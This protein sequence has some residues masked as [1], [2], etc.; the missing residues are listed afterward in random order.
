MEHASRLRYAHFAQ[1][2]L[3]IHMRCTLPVGSFVA[4]MQL[5]RHVMR[6]GK[7]KLTSHA[8]H[9]HV[10]VARRHIVFDIEVIIKANL[11]DPRAERIGE[12][13]L[14][15]RIDI[16]RIIERTIRV[17]TRQ[18][19]ES[20]KLPCRYG[21]DN[22]GAQPLRKSSGVHLV[23]HGI[24]ERHQGIHAGTAGTPQ[25]LK[26]VLVP[27]REQMRMGVVQR[28]PRLRR[29]DGLLLFDECRRVNAI[30]HVQAPGQAR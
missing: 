26:R 25:T 14:D 13:R 7:F 6:T 12:C 15:A 24:D 27:K 10:V 5:D 30:E 2:A 8:R 28:G 19:F 21:L 11:A 9:L 22:R 4:Q 1:D 29:R 16:V 20:G 23:A 17:H 3:G 18:I